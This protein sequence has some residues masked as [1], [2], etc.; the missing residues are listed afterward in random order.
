[1]EIQ[2]ACQPL[3][4]TVSALTAIL[5]FNAMEILA[6]L[7]VLVLQILALALVSVVELPIVETKIVLL[8]VIAYQILVMVELALIAK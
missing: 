3:V 7:T 1:M 4:S 2:I 6:H 8:T 5:L